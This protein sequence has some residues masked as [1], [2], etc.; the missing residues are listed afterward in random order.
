MPELTFDQ[1]AAWIRRSEADL[2]AFTNALAE[3]LEQGMPGF[4]EVDRKKDGFFSHQQHVERLVVH[5][6]DLDYV[7]NFHGARVE[8]L[9]ARVV[10]GVVLKREE[11]SLAQW[12]Q[13]LLQDTAMI[14]AEM[15]EASQSLHDFLLQ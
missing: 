11:L 13:G 9:R 10:R 4:V 8:T 12:L 6:G 14:S 7:L 15:Q 3:R 2:H 1:N 5:T